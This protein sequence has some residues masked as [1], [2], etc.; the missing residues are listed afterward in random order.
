ML[1]NCVHLCHHHKEEKKLNNYLYYSLVPL[2]SILFLILGIIL[3]NFFSYLL[4]ALSA[5]MLIFFLY[6]AKIKKQDH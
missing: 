4:Y 2:A 3:G 1:N 5:F 6:F